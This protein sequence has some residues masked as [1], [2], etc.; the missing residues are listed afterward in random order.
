MLLLWLE[1]VLDGRTYFCNFQPLRSSGMLFYPWLEIVQPVVNPPQFFCPFFLLACLDPTVGRFYTVV[2]TRYITP[3][4]PTAC[5]R[6]HN[7][8][9]ATI[10]DTSSWLIIN[11]CSKHC[12]LGVAFSPCY[13]HVTNASEK[14]YTRF[15]RD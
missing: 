8:Q 9:S 2:R 14:M 3:Y 10:A 1:I 12:W 7:F 6:C 5:S 11:V 13:G 4:G 15:L